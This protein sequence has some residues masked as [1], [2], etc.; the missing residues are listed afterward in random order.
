VPWTSKVRAKSIDTLSPTV[1][2][3][4][5]QVEAVFS[6]PNFETDVAMRSPILSLHPS[7]LQGTTQ[8]EFQRAF[9]SNMSS[10]N[11]S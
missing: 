2:G 9:A 7:S 10:F 1:L 5:L 6:V 8:T 11:E 4:A 3:T